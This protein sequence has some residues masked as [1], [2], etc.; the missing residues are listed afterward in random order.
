LA[1]PPRISNRAKERER[2]REE[3]EKEWERQHRGN[4]VAVAKQ[5][6]GVAHGT[7]YE[8]VRV[9]QRRRFI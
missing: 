9:I 6:T 3:G 8:T 7:C 4:A 2:E 1:R 5:Q